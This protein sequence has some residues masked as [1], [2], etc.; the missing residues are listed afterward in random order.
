MI[1]SFKHKG[2]Q[3]FFD[4]GSIK[5]INAKHAVRLKTQLQILNIMK[6]IEDANVPSW[7]LHSLSG[8][9]K[10]HWSLKVNG[11]WRITFKFDGEDVYIVDYQDYH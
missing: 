9:S 7:N 3:K 1:K 10:D 8:E 2:L 11:N 4:T 6:N 5:G